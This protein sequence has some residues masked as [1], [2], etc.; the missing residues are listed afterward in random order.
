M[1]KTLLVVLFFGSKM[2]HS[3]PLLFENYSSAQGLSQNS[4]YA[5][6]QDNHGFMWLGT[7]DG[8]NRFDGKQYKVFLPQTAK[9]KKLPCNN[10]TALHFDKYNNQLWIGTLRG[11]RLYDTKG[12]SIA[13]VSEI[14]PY[15]SALD[16]LM[17]KKII[18]FK[19]NEYWIISYNMGLLHINAKERSVSSFFT[20]AGLQYQVSAMTLHNGEIIVGLL[21]R[22]FKMQVS[23]NGYQPQAILQD[24]HFPEINELFSHRNALWI[25]SLNGCFYID[26][27]LG[28]SAD[29]QLLKTIAGGVGSFAADADDNLWIG[30]RGQGILKYDHASNSLSAAVHNDYDDRSLGKN[31]VLCLLKDRQGL[32]WCGLSGGGVAKFDP[33]KYQFGS[34]RHEANRPSSLPDNMVFDI[35]KCSDGAYF[36]GTQN[37]GL[38]EWD[39]ENNRFTPFPDIAGLGA[40]AHTIYDMAEGDNHNLWVAGWGGL[41]E[42]DR[43]SKK[44]V[45]HSPG[46]IRATQKFYAVAKLRNADSLFLMGETGASFYS[47]KEKKWQRC[48]ESILPS[49]PYV[50]R[51]IFEDDQ[52]ILWICTIGAGLI[53]YDYRKKDFRV[54]EKVRD[55]SIT[56]RHIF[57]DSSLFLIGTDN[58]V[59]VYDYKED[60][61]IKQT[62]P[63]IAD[64]SRV[65]YAIQK[66]KQGFYWVSTN[67]GLFKISPGDYHIEKKYNQGNG[68]SFLEYNTACVIADED[69]MMI[70]GGVN[71][72][73]SFN[74]ALLKENIFSPAPII[75]AIGVNNKP[76]L[77]NQ[78]PAAIRELQLNHAENFLTFHFT[79]TN[80]SNER[81]NQFRFRL[82]G[83]NDEWSHADPGNTATFTSLPPGNYTFELRSANSDGKWSRDITTLAITIHPPWWQAW[84]LRAVAIALLAGLI[85][86]FTRRRIKTIRREAAQK[87]QLAELEIKGLHAQMNPHFIFNCLNSIKEM[88]LEDEKKNASRY[89]SK[90][91]QL[92]RTNLEQSRQSFISVKQCVDHLQQYLEME[93]LRFEDF[94][95]SIEIEQDRNIEHLKMAPMLVQPLVENALWHGIR[96]INGEKKLSIRFYTHTGQLICEIEDNGVG[97]LKS[98]EAKNGF[99]AAHRSLG[100]T[101]IFE[102]LKVLNEK[103]NLKCSLTIKD[104]SELPER[105]DCGTIVFLKFNL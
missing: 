64:D 36:V 27:N 52:N 105:N 57:R 22:L 81:N 19:E 95:Y 12:D 45:Y 75:T 31:F 90:F 34:I 20:D 68:L 85:V 32:I 9:G 104:K 4:C 87:Q 79:V 41:M 42:L 91:A 101:N 97:Y 66:D 61:L 102:R 47:I 53:R 11:L 37:S 74:P 35:F 76:R 94:K 21:N 51:F 44:M 67:S 84:W 28:S 2:L 24:H 55:V 38:C 88:I 50:G 71:G 59:V 56:A 46:D 77:L 33:L 23:Q 14:F 99:L 65:C 93:K 48:P 89:L 43:R 62:V 30:T 73:T 49:N 5:M 25:G 18:S 82:K 69:G 1:Y 103:Y 29:V 96:G 6:A 39:R 7:Q 58:G 80:F 86:F 100:I 8:L 10:I 17:V 92:I 3:Q 78:N 70:F 16:N 54:I 15:A 72:I 60:R 98:I 40:A 83:L 63:G 26:G 13:L